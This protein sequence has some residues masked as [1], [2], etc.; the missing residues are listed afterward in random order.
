MLYRRPLRTTNFLLEEEYLKL[1]GAAL[2]LLASIIATFLSAWF[3]PVSAVPLAVAAADSPQSAIRH[4]VVIFQENRSTDNLFHELP[5]A[6]IANSGRNS[7]GDVIPLEPLPMDSDYDL[8]HKHDAFVAMYDHGKMDGADKVDVI[9][10]YGSRHCPPDNPQFKYVKPGD[11]KPYF[12]MAETYAFGDRM[13]QTNQGPSFPAHQFIISGTSAPTASSPYFA[14]ENPAGGAKHPGFKT[15]CTAPKDEYV[16][17]INPSGHEVKNLYPCYEHGALSDLL[18]NA[19]LNWRYYTPNPD[20]LWTGPNAIHHIRFGPDWQSVIVGQ[21]HIL[22]DI[23]RGKLPSVS[24]V[25]PGGLQSDHAGSTNGSG[26]SWVASI[27]NAIGR[28]QYWSSTAIFITWDDWGGWYDHVAP[29]VIHDG[30]S[31]GSGY[32]YGFRVPLVIV[33]PYA[34]PGYVSHVTHDFSSILKFAEEVFGLPSLGFGDAH[35]DDLFDCFNFQQ[36]PQAFHQIAAPYDESYFLN[37][38][39]P[40]TDPDDD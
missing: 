26:P 13:F 33:S 1:A 29:K 37:D 36:Q 10:N 6:D 32:V 20:F 21:A 30:H 15:G 8:G 25:I 14:A 11:V 39:R 3:G 17:L 7:K 2:L 35:A 18:D 19:G 34:N 5:N 23:K 12:Q 4:V 31:W 27:V 16:T 40:P 38:K 28:S 24:W 22:R 9:C